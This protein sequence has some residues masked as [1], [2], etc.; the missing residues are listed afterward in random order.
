M[1]LSGV[2][3][4]GSNVGRKGLST[5]RCDM[6]VERARQR[7]NA[8]TASALNTHQSRSRPREQASVASVFF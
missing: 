8:Q 2:D 4:W 3:V 1:Q 7:A 5:G 6:Q